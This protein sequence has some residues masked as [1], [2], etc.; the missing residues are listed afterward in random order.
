MFCYV[1][2]CNVLYV[3]YFKK[4]G[5]NIV[6]CRKCWQYFCMQ[7]YH[8]V[9]CFNLHRQNCRKHSSAAMDIEKTHTKET[10]DNDNQKKQKTN[11]INQEQI[12]CPKCKTEPRFRFVVFFCVCVNFLFIHFFLFCLLAFTFFF[13][14]EYISKKTKKKNK[15]K[16][17]K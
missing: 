16:K 6:E 14:L 2:V 12:R 4:D 5:S 1:F 8:R 10:I 3:M 9:D 13:W 15:K 17:N 11:A 7:C